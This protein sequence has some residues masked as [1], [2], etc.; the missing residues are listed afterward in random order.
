[1]PDATPDNLGAPPP[2]TSDTSR[3]NFVTVAE[4]AKILGVSPRSIQRRCQT[5]TLGARRV[6]SK[7]GEA[8]E[9]DRAQ[10][11]KAALEASTPPRQ[12]HDATPDKAPTEAR[13][14]APITEDLSARYI[15]RL[16]TENDFLRATVEQ[17]QRSEAELRAALREAL[18]MQPRQLTASE[19]STSARSALQSPQT[20]VIGDD[21]HDATSVSLRAPDRAQ[22]GLGYNDIADELERRLN[23][24]T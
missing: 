22:T 1:M 23:H 15:A 24:E 17:H 11:E 8:W 20:D 14:V 3:L 13:R 6:E 19:P 9:I 4:A 21:S 7:F 10:V 5:G 18:K 2:T 16:E 12:R